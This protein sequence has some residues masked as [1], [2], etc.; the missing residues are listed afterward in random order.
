[1][2]GIIGVRVKHEVK[3]YN[4]LRCFFLK[5]LKIDVDN[6]AI[7][8]SNKFVPQGFKAAGISMLIKN[9]WLDSPAN[10][11][12]ACSY[13]AKTY[14]DD[15]F[16]YTVSKNQDG[17]P[18][19]NEADME[20]MRDME[21]NKTNA[22]D[23]K[24]LVT[25]Q[26][27]WFRAMKSLAA[28]VGPVQFAEVGDCM[29]W[30]LQNKQVKLHPDV[31]SSKVNSSA[32]NLALFPTFQKVFDSPAA[33]NRVDLAYIVF[34]ADATNKLRQ[35]HDPPDELQIPGFYSPLLAGVPRANANAGNIRAKQK[36]IKKR[37]LVRQ[38]PTRAPMRL[39]DL[40]PWQRK[41][42]NLLRHGSHEQQR[43]LFWLHNER[44][45]VGKSTLAA[46]LC[47]RLDALIL[48][49]A[50]EADI[51][52]AIYDDFVT[53]GRK[54]RLIYIM[55][56]PRAAGATAPY[57]TIEKL[58]SGR[59]VNTKYVGDNMY[60]DPCLVVVLANQPP[61]REGTWSKDRL[62]TNDKVSTVIDLAG[63]EKEC[64]ERRANTEHCGRGT[65]H[66]VA[67]FEF[68]RDVAKLPNDELERLP[69]YKVALDAAAAAD[70]NDD[71]DVDDDDDQDFPEIDQD[72]PDY[73]ED[74]CVEPHSSEPNGSSATPVR[75]QTPSSAP[76][77]VAAASP[78][79]DPG[80]QARN[81]RHIAVAT[82]RARHNRERARS[83]L[84]DVPLLNYGGIDMDD[85]GFGPEDE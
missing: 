77:N 75:P 7:T 55:D 69:C 25:V 60:I 64:D 42:V 54:G 17:E 38:R 80:K 34:G 29:L 85:T 58:L 3:D 10:L 74:G 62:Y 2:Q 21:D 31:V 63:V 47:E 26:A 68:Y 78:R 53:N 22:L 19:F 9:L 16:K 76:A 30:L 79:R 49:A 46:F 1:M 70:G 52:N 67:L 48:T 37:L 28:P 82:P 65:D 32:M 18:W 56:I 24:K 6:N 12:S 20:R 57:Q 51:L 35:R 4:R 61:D 45:Y 15:G 40:L 39:E 14:G 84:G 8:I 36:E 83:P 72:L 44:G 11:L 43:H 66:D 71:V 50:D 27:L 13:F 41:V 33:L 23:N 59:L 81:R 5:K 73:G